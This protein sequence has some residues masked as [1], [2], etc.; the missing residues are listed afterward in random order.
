MFPMRD[1][2]N[3]EAHEAP[4]DGSAESRR[5]ERL[6]ALVAD[7]HLGVLVTH[8]RDGRAQ[9]SNVAYDY[10][11]GER[12]IRVS[13]TDGRAKTANLRRDPRA[14]FHV[15][16]EDFWAYTV[17][18]GTASLTPVAAA[19]DDATVEELVS[20]FRAVQGEHPDWD[21][22]RTAMVDERRLVIR[23]PVEHVYGQTR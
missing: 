19:P 14:S 1:Q 18:E 22:F 4:R 12:M 7:R 21:E 8:K 13:V 9:L 15:T 20:L 17:V 16:T 23:V 2:P 5:R 10:D 6:L 11:E 3:P